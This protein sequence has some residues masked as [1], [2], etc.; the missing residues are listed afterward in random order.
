MISNNASF[1]SQF[2]KAAAHADPT[3]STRLSKGMKRLGPSYNNTAKLSSNNWTFNKTLSN[4][5][6]Q[7]S[8]LSTVRSMSS[9]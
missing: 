7:D 5:I 3:A 9:H 4:L 8:P 1:S 2:R 6:R